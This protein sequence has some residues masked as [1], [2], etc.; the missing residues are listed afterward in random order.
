MVRTYSFDYRLRQKLVVSPRYL[1]YAYS[2]AL[3]RG[4]LANYIA[5]LAIVHI[6]LKVC[7]DF[8]FMIYSYKIAFPWSCVLIKLTNGFPMKV[9]H[10]IIYEF[11]KHFE[12][13]RHHGLISGWIDMAT[14]WVNEISGGVRKMPHNV[15]KKRLCFINK[16]VRIKRSQLSVCYDEKREPDHQCAHRCRW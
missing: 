9:L 8:N 3:F 14:W 4:L 10:F 1:F 6:I 5:A 2:P 12:G 7:I 16:I 13:L 11:I 15:P